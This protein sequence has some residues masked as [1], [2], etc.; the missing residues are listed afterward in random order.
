MIPYAWH[1]L[2]ENLNMKKLFIPALA[3]IFFAACAGNR[4]I[5]NKKMAKY[6][7][8]EYIT[9]IA[10]AQDKKAAKEVAVE[11]LKKIFDGLGNYQDSAVRRENILSQ[12]RAEQWWKDKASGKYYAIAVLERAPAQLILRP[13]YEP[14]DGKLE[15]LRARVTGEQDKYVRLKNAVQMQP[16]F[17]QRQQLDNE[18]KLLAFNA[19]AY[20]ED[21]LYAFKSVYNKT[22]YD[23][24]INAEIFGVSD[25]SVK[26]Y[27]IDALNSIGFYVGEGLTAY[28]IGLVIKTSV[29]KYVS[30][31]TDGLFWSTAT[32]NVSLRDAATGGVFAAFTK[33][34]RDGS[35][36]EDEARRRSLIAVGADSAPII[37]QKILEYIQKK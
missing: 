6:P 15:N 11:E 33:S 22:F 27:L 9:K 21:K 3:I 7:A 14:I 18:Y 17:A 19:S 4:N 25:E 32:I 13:Y 8:A 1:I 20:D 30:K 28:D 37:K 26:I 23:I 2:E 10:S 5:L 12:I 24:K 35:M 31:S 36:R 16:L 29:D 34:E